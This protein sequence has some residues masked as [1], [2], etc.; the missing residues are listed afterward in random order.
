M[1]NKYYINDP[2]DLTGYG[3]PLVAVK[4]SELEN[5]AAATAALLKTIPDKLSPSGTLDLSEVIFYAYS[6]SAKGNY[7]M[8][9]TL[10]MNTAAA[11]FKVWE[12]AFDKAVP[13]YRSSARWKSIFT[14][15]STAMLKQF[16]A[17]SND[18]HVL[19]MFFPLTYYNN[20]TNPNWN[21]AIQKLQWNGPINWQQYGW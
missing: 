17:I 21:T 16:D 8:Y 4:T 14:T 7:D 20:K 11:D 1:A 19:A 9:K 2:G 3:V 5:L 15:L 6:N 12:D 18:S 13:Y 10:K